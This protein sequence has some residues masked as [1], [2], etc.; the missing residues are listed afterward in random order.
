MTVVAAFTA[1]FNLMGTA[2]GSER[3]SHH[4]AGVSNTENSGEI[5]PLY[6][7]D[8]VKAVKD[9]DFGS[10]LCGHVSHGSHGSHGSHSSH[11]S[12]FSH[13]SSRVF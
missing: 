2:E 1:L 7:D 10:V 12:H 6:L 13:Y 3:V 8:A 4:E 11:S 9:G 5:M